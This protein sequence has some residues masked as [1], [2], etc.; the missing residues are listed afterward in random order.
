ML[1]HGGMVSPNAAQQ[2]SAERLQSILATQLP[3]LARLLFHV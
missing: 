1:Q 3:Y 2:M